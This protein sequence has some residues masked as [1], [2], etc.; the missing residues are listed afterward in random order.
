MLIG[1][2]DSI[3]RTHP[4][5][6]RAGI[7]IQKLPFKFIRLEL[8]SFETVN[9]QTICF[10]ALQLTVVEE[11][12]TTFVARRRTNHIHQYWCADLKCIG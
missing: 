9:F 3:Y 4:V 10:N 11:E 6:F 5:T 1:I 12:S 8:M 7:S 2:F